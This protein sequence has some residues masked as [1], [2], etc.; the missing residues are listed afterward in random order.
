MI[1]ENLFAMDG[2]ADSMDIGLSKLPEL[3]MDG[4]AW[5]ATVPGVTKSQT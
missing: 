5:C 3:V 1:F 2:I 4:E